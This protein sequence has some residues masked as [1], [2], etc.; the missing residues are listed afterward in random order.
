[1]SGAK[2]IGKGT[3]PVT[4]ADRRPK[5]GEVVDWEPEAVKWLL[6]RSDFA[7][8]EDVPQVPAPNISSK[9]K[10]TRKKGS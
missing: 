3:C 6:L 4:V 9:R 10:T 2:Y 5:P 1:M 7:P 8:V